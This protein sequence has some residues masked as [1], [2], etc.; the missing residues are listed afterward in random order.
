[1]SARPTEHSQIRGHFYAVL[2]AF[3]H[4]RLDFDLLKVT[5]SA[6]RNV[7]PFIACNV[8]ELLVNSVNDRFAVVN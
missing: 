3:Q 8:I 5:V 1:M 2:C 7:S 4:A 6:Q